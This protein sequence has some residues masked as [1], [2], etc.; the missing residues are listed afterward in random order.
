[1]DMTGNV[2]EWCLT[3]WGKEIAELGGYTYRAMR[4]GA[5][6][7]SNLENLRAV[8]RYGHS[9]RGQLNDAGFRIVCAEA[10]Q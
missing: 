5:W 4:G 2:W 10:G 8:T 9:P 1:M 3:A 7:V 6:N